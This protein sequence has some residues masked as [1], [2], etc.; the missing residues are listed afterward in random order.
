MP[1]ETPGQPAGPQTPT[2]PAPLVPSAL[3]RAR[4][5]QARRGAERA[6]AR[7]LTGCAAAPEA[8]DPDPREA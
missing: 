4:R 1:D 5:A 8:E 3:G 7:G 6:D 2:H